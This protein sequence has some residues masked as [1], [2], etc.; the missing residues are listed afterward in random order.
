M[1]SGQEIGLGDALMISLVGMV[2]VLLVLC[3][4]IGI[5]TILGKVV[6]GGAGTVQKVTAVADVISRP[7]APVSPADMPDEEVAVIIAAAI[8]ETGKQ[9]DQVRVTSITNS[10]EG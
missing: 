7:E 2:I 6:S 4:M 9:P 10:K 5:I 1:L 3:V 8:A